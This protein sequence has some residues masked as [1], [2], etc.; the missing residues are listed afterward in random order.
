MAKWTEDEDQQLREHLSTG[1]TYSQIALKMGKT[2]GQIA[3]RCSR[4]NLKK[5]KTPSKSI[6]NV[7]AMKPR[8]LFEDNQAVLNLKQGEC[9]F[10][11]GDVAKKDFAFCSEEVRPGS[12]YCPSHHKLCYVPPKID[13]KLWGIR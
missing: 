10:P 2:N 6:I 11:L 13:K 12:P 7:K 1:L 8:I 4:L 5:P 3:G 9:K